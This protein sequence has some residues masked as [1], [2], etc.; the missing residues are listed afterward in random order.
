MIGRNRVRDSRQRHNS[1][2]QCSIDI[3]RT[4]F[5]PAGACSRHA[6]Q[7]V[8]VATSGVTLRLVPATSPLSCPVSPKLCR[9]GR[10]TTG[11]ARHLRRCRLLDQ[12]GGAEPRRSDLRTRVL[13]L[14]QKRHRQ[15]AGG[16]YIVDQ[17]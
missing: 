16:V 11:V 2:Q 14:R 1:F 9:R 10:A 12:P 4:V 6:T 17:Q 13:A 15:G 5:G 3:E 8:T 7:P